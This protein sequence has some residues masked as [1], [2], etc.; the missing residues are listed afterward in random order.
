M[1]KFLF[2]IFVSFCLFSCFDRTDAVGWEYNNPH[3]G[4]FQ[5][6]PYIEQETPPG[7]VM[8]EGAEILVNYTENKK[9]SLVVSTFYIS[10]Y[11]ETNGQYLAYLSYAK[12]YY[13]EPTY[14]NALPDTTVWKKENIDSNKCIYFINNYL[15]SPYYEDFP[16]V[17]LTPIQINNYA[18]WKTDRLNEFILI[19]EGVLPVH[20]EAKDSSNLFT[21]EAYLM[22]QYPT[23]DDEILDL[24]PN[25]R[26]E[27]D[28]RHV[29][30][31]DGVLFPHIRM[32]TSTEWQLAHLNIGN[33][34]HKY[35]KTAKPFRFKKYDK[36]EYFSY[37]ND[38]KKETKN[39]KFPVNIRIKGL[40]KVYYASRNNYEV[41]GLN[42]NASE[43][44]GDSAFYQ[45]IGGSF[46]DPI[47]DNSAVFVDGKYEITHPLH[48]S[49]SLDHN[50]SGLYGF[51]LAMDRLGSPIAFK[52][53]THK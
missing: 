26:G 44:V 1:Y 31:E 36:D 35:L 8:V 20:T 29:R 23:Y 42:T 7:M 37:L 51:R 50:Q 16:V 10:K 49:K 53:R 12:R 47:P 25:T 41:Y 22:N 52:R 2:P 30:M 38:V 27:L 40:N 9:D 19:R 39:E 14:K 21:T 13:S 6:V 5:K 33:E 3:N 32:L 45:I 34:K 24:N 28:E 17:G 46:K 18:S 48:N 11:E 4:G 15:R 43:I